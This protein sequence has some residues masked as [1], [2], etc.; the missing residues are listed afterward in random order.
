M[1]NFWD[2]I[3]A[4]A[5][6]VAASDGELIEIRSWLTELIAICREYREENPNVSE[7]QMVIHL[8]T[9]LHFELKGDSKLIAIYLAMLIAMNAEPITNLPDWNLS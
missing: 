9:K 2:Q 4:T 5:A 1:S 7:T 6:Q 3:G 8:T